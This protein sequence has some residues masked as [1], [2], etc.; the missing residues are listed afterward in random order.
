[1]NM[2]WK[3]VEI[4]ELRG[5]VIEWAEPD[6]Y[7]LSRR[8]QI[9]R[10]KELKPPFEHI[11]DFTAPYW[12]EVVSIS[13][14]GQ[15]LLRFS[16]NN[17]I[18]LAN[19]DIFVS[20]DKSVGL[21]RNGKYLPLGGLNRP[22][23]TLRSSIAV[24]ANGD[25]YFGE[26]ISNPDRT[27]ISIYRYKPGSD[28][29]E[30]ISEVEGIRHIH[31]IYRDPYEDS[32]LC[33]TGDSAGECRILRSS[34]R[35]LSFE[36]LGSGDESWRAVSAIFTQDAIFYG[37]DAEHRTNVI[38]RL[39]RVTRERRNIGEVGGTVFYS[40]AL[41]DDVFFATTAEGAP[42]Q[43][44]NVATIC[45]LTSSLGLSEIAKFRKDR[46]N[47]ILFGFGTI[48]FPNIYSSPE[49]LFFHLSALDRDNSTFELIATV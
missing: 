1:M 39:D 9:Y 19:G 42:G 17:M 47:R 5:Y 8:N 43:A 16:V 46:W 21:I 26:Y 3:V 45:R 41:K 48:Y 12:R 25:L 35:F 29:V 27:R 13:R 36:E 49:R 33:L 24:G 14:L 28:S 7:L 6:N 34:D 32:F 30:A 40:Q 10:S 37:T 38:F 2:T 11:A 15:R 22:C 31:G 23:R 44:E 4:P 18:P 20:F